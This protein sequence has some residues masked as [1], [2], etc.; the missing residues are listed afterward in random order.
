MKTP[1]L[2][3]KKFGRLTVLFPVGSL[4][5]KKYWLCQCDC[6]EELCVNTNSLTSGKTQSCG[7]Y[8][9]ERAIEAN[10]KHGKRHTKIYNTYRG[11]K[12]R[13]FNKNN[14]KYKNYGGRGISMCDEWKNDFMC[15]Y[16]WAMDNGYE[17]TLTI[18]RINVNGNYEPSN[19]K[20]I[21]ACE[22]AKNRTTNIFI[23][24]NGETKILSEW[25]KD[26]G[27]SYKKIHLRL[28]Y[29]IPIEKIFSNYDL[30][31]KK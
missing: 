1:D 28:S 23:K 19:C 30:R 26:L 16:N 24:Y 5:G 6:G 31:S 17:E 2:E 29:G 10:I 27:L 15:F 7:C 3:D 9:R 4:K 20:W 18:E 12:D 13:C 11:M 21:P 22:Q 25:C 14:P 8:A